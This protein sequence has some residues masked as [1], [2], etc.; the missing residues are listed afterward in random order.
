MYG[1]T[2]PLVYALRT[3][4]NFTFESLWMFLGSILW[5]ESS[6]LMITKVEQYFTASLSN[7]SIYFESYPYNTSLV[8]IYAPEITVIQIVGDV[9]LYSFLI[10]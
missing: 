4:E 2:Y 3:T 7:V 9:F 5:S 8:I 6:A 1:E 10:S